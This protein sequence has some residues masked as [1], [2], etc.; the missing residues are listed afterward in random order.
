MEHHVINAVNRGEATKGELRTSRLQGKIPAVTYGSG[1][2]A[3]Q[4]FINEAEFLTALSGITESTIIDLAV[5][6]QIVQAFVKERQRAAIT[7]RIIHVDFLEIT[8]GRILHAKVPIHLTGS[9]VGI[10]EG[11]ILE[12]PG[13]EI[14]VE[15]D[16]SRLPEKIDLDV[17]ELHVNHSI[18][19]RDV[20]AIEG[21]RILSNPD[22]VLVAIKYA[23]GEEVA[24]VAEPAAGAPVAGAVAGAGT[25]A[26]AAPASVEKKA[27]KK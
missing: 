20:P 23:R 16:P 3:R 1:K 18:H 24:A 15:C 10:R 14:E 17:S 25:P 2:A 19:V 12:N 9:A 26:V 7:H 6:G 8:A 4:I 22:Q 21:V 13:H 11:G 27:E 5:E